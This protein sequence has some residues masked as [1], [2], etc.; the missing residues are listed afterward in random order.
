MINLI[1]LKTEEIKSI[2]TNEFETLTVKRECFNEGWWKGYAMAGVGF[3]LGEI[4][5]E[6]WIKKSKG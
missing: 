5:G 3:I 4:I 1:G 2:P 6:I